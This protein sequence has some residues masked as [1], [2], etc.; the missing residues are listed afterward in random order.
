MS[1]KNIP[2]FMPMATFASS[3]L[4]GSYQAIN[5]SGFPEQ[6]L[7]IDIYNKSSTDITVSFDGTTDNLYIPTGTAR[8]FSSNAISSQTADS[9]KFPKGL[10]VYVKGTAGTGNVY[11]TG[12][13]LASN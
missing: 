9:V 4:T 5:S 7:S 3:S 6:M 13:Y 11:L 1:F 10:V 2:I 8:T 12:F